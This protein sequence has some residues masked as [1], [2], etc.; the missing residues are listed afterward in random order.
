MTPPLSTTTFSGS[1]APR[2]K[3]DPATLHVAPNL[4]SFCPT[5]LRS[6]ILA[7]VALVPC[8]AAAADPQ[9]APATAKEPQGKFD[10]LIRQLGDKDYYVRQRAQEELARSGFEAFEAVAAATNDADPEIASRANYLLRL[11]RMEWTTENDPPEVKRQLRDYDSLDPRVRQA[12]MQVLAALPK[13][14]GV[15]A[16]CR[17]LRFE[18]SSQMSKLAALALLLQ[19]RDT[20]PSAAAA[21]AIRKALTG[22]KRPAALWLL[23]WTRLRTEPDPA[24]DE[25]SKLVDAEKATL[26]RTPDETTPDILANLTRCQVAWLK[27]FGKTDQAMAAIRR[28]VELQRGN[29]EMLGE[30]LDWLIEQKEWKSID[31]LATR[32][33]GRFATDP[34]LLY[35]L[36]EAHAQ[37]GK[38]TQAEEMASRAMRLLPGRVEVSLIRHVQVAQ[39][40]VTRGRFDWARREFHNV[41]NLTEANPNEATVAAWRRLALMQHDQGDDRDAAATLDKLVAAIDAG[42]VTDGEL[43]GEKPKDIRSQAHYYAACHWHAQHDL[44]RERKAL[45]KALE[46][47]PEDIDVLIASHR[48]PKQPAEFRAKIADLIKTVAATLHEQITEEPEASDGYNNYAWL[49]GNTEGDSD[50]ALRA[51]QKAVEIDP[52]RAGYYDTLAHVYAHRGDFDSAV[53]FQAKAIKLDPHSGLIH[54]TL[55]EYRKKLEDKNN[56]AK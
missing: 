2:E 3:F 52:D 24:L 37:Q 7:V 53:K 44:A 50:E 15:G 13:S 55:D 34:S 29:P 21:E 8:V 26:K 40:L 33:P 19:D 32:F 1:H 27:R 45:D 28:L 56:A 12:R 41:I 47:N 4:E 51:A 23:C 48:L 43:W 54:R 9:P 6:I 14:Q 17:L 11:M 39:Q 38:T 31:E 20:P 42:R 30:L 22:C 5:V 16:L 18:K 36:A 49:V 10:K 25:W 46:D 35:M